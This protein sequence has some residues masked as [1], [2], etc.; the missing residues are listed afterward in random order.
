MADFLFDG[1]NRLIIE[2][3]GSGNTNFEVGRDIYS[4]WKRWTQTGVGSQFLNAF[5]VEGG[6]PIGATGLFTGATFLLVN[7]WKVRAAEHDHQLTLSGNLYSDDGIVSVP[8]L[9]ANATVFV[10]A[11]VAAQGIATGSGGSGGLTA[12]QEAK[13]DATLVYARK[14]AYDDEYSIREVSGN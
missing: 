13:L 5:T 14:A 10:S 11:S 8:S 4:A 3:S 6:T 2:P 7:G 1:P 12:Q 9:T